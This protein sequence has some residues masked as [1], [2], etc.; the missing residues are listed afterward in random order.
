LAGGNT[1]Y[2][3]QVNSKNPPTSDAPAKNTA[4]LTDGNGMTTSSDDTTTKGTV[5]GLGIAGPNTDLLGNLGA[6]LG[7]LTGGKQTTAPPSK[8]PVPVS[9]TLAGIATVQ[10]VKSESSTTLGTKTFT[11][12]AQAAASNIELLN[13]LISIKGVDMTAQ[14]VSDGKKASNTGHA[15][16]DGIG[17]AKQVISLDDKGLNLADSTVT[18]P[19]LPDTLSSALNQIGISIKTVQAKHTVDGAGGTFS[20]KGLI[21][22]VNTKP[23]KSALS[24]PFGVLADI[25]AKLPQQAADQLGPLVNFAPKFVITVGDVASGASAS[26]AFDGGSLPGGTSTGGTG[27]G[28]AGGGTTGGA[29]TGT[30]GGTL[31]G[32]GGTG[33]SAPNTGSLPAGTT[34]SSTQATSYKLPG[35]GAVPRILILGGLALAGALGWAIRAAGGFVLGGGRDCAYGLTTGVPDLRK[36]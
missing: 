2:P 32:G 11:A 22:T 15:T 6:G 3:I 19:G 25:I 20:A 24:A 9:S 14:T 16:I 4:Q 31:G 18:L 10:N 5:T 13:G 29:A 30:G 26:P 17:I 1:N 23:L 34:T 35:L 36:G 12:S 27:G 21:I 7:Q 28:V 33:G 8:Q